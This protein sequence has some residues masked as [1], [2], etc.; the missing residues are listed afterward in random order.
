MSDL[1]FLQIMVLQKAEHDAWLT[2]VAEWRTAGLPDMND[3]SMDAAIR[4]VE[5]WAERRVALRLSQDE[6][7]RA[8]A[9]TD[10][11]A[12]YR[13]VATVTP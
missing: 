2:F 12:D 7:L 6:T 3:P 11:T 4:A 8:V 10:K 1:D 13:R 5:V 9:L